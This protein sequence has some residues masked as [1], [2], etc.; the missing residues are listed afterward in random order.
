MPVFTLEAD[1]YTT[2]QFRV[3]RPRVQVNYTVEAEAPITVLVLDRAGRAAWTRR[4]PLNEY[5]GGRNRMYHTDEITLARGEYWLLISNPQNH[6]V[7]VSW[8][9]E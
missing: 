6:S 8:E 4:E 9:L 1:T 7:A 5:S 2:I 3:T